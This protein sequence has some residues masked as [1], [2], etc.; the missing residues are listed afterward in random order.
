VLVLR[1]VVDQEQELGRRQPLDQTVQQGLGLGINPMQVLTDEQQ[2]LHLA[3][4]QQK[5]L[6]GLQRALA[7]QRRSELQKRTI[8]RQRRE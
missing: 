1:A 3:V 6:Q 2:R 7:A 5:P 4:A 8:R